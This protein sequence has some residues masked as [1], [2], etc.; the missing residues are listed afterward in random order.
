MHFFGAVPPEHAA[1]AG[2]EGRSAPSTMRFHAPVPKALHSSLP[3]G[4]IAAPDSCFLASVFAR[5]DGIV[6]WA[7]VIS[8]NA[9]AMQR[10]LQVARL[11]VASLL[12]SDGVS[13][14][15]FAEGLRL[16]EQQAGRT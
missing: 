6:A 11:G 4:T 15:V 9:Y 5:L 8:W 14:T 10:A 13:A 12:V 16:Y 1:G 2:G 3:V 7:G